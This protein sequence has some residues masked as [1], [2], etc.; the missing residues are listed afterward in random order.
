MDSLINA[1][2]RLLAAG[3]PIAALKLVALRNDA[4][5][6]ALRGIALAQLGEHQRA[7]E[8]LRTAAR[9]F[10]AREA[11]ARAR[12]VV[13]EVE[14]AL[15]SRDLGWAAKRLDG[16]RAVLD[17]HGDAVN[18]AHARYLGMRRLLLTG[19]L[20]DLERDLSSAPGVAAL[21]LTLQVGHH[22]LVAQLAIRRLQVKAARAALA[23][24]AR[25]ARRT[26]IP[27]LVAEVDA[28]AAKLEAPAARKVGRAGRG[29]LPVCGA[30]G[31]HDHS[32]RHAPGAA[33]HRPHYG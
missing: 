33:R 20:E 2:A 28:A 19:R 18:A 7:R 30:R 11:L 4:S 21:P 16:A 24:A 13:A 23:R 3:D 9:A 1:A 17:S 32:P 31:R 29:R 15:A 25:A 10:G 8:L 5:G 22:L 6:L 27:A 26:G 12:C 14:I